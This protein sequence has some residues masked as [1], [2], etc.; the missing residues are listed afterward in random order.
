MCRAGRHNVRS[1]CAGGSLQVLQSN[2]RW[3]E[4]VDL[5]V[6]SNTLWV[7]EKTPCLTYGMRGM[8][9]LSVE[10]LLPPPL[11]PLVPNF[12]LVPSLVR[13]PTSHSNQ[14]RL[15]AIQCSAP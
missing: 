10:V 4:G 12:S 15:F 11:V 13:S 7:G 3:F 6:I 9:S 5:I 8:L 2:K 14:L 1:G